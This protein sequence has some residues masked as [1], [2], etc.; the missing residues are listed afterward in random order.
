MPN[1]KKPIIKPILATFKNLQT[2]ETFFIPYTIEEVKKLPR[3]HYQIK[4]PSH[5]SALITIDYFAE[6]D[7]MNAAMQKLVKLMS[8]EN[9]V[10]KTA[11]IKTCLAV[12]GIKSLAIFH[13]T[14]LFL[15]PFRHL[16]LDD[17]LAFK[18]SVEERAPLHKQKLRFLFGLGAIIP[19]INM[20]KDQEE[21][22]AVYQFC[23]AIN[24]L[25]AEEIISAVWSLRPY[26]QDGSYELF[27]D[28][29]IKLQIPLT[30]CH[31]DFLQCGTFLHQEFAN[32]M[33][34]KEG[35]ALI[36][37]IESKRNTN[38][39]QQYAC[40]DYTIRD[41]VYGHTV[42]AI[43]ILMRNEAVVLKLLQLNAKGISVG[44]NLP[45]QKGQTPLLLAVA[46]GLPNVVAELIKQGAELSVV[47]QQGHALK[48]YL[49]LSP[50]ALREIV[51][52]IILEPNRVATA[53]R[54]YLH[55]KKNN[56]MWCW[57]EANEVQK[58]DDEQLTHLIVWS[59]LEKHLKRLIKV[60][61]YFKENH[62]AEEL[63]NV[64]VNIMRFFD[65]TVKEVE[66]AYVHGKLFE[67][68]KDKKTF[69]DVCIEGQILVRQLLEKNLRLACAFGEEEKVKLLLEIGINPNAADERKRTALHY[70]IAREG[71]VQQFA[72]AAGLHWQ[73]PQ[74]RAACHKHAAILELLLAVNVDIDA[75]HEG[76]LTAQ[77]VLQ[78]YKE[79]G[80]FDQ[81]IAEQCIIEFNQFLLS[82]DQSARL[83]S[84]FNTA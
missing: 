49:N 59:P 69:L 15:N 83:V 47:D 57:Y 7:V 8:D 6:Q 78:K 51:V 17:S 33:P 60:A 23:R 39:K 56:L 29:L 11:E 62:D 42:L 35:I 30:I 61:E 28:T 46:V 41:T 22:I 1:S 21:A 75:K 2:Q 80:G 9:Y 65:V 50:A 13:L 14:N 38:P 43:A 84:T 19:D 81:E 27:L 71:L 18:K 40:F 79:S 72:K 26:C 31:P 67:L 66:D 20:M 25:S 5:Q 82:H 16:M 77:E 53:Q 64:L 37:L 34:A 55:A 44:I 54:S 32:E 73:T 45:N 68:L 3:G 48:T 58:T 24:F 12:P 10:Q 63:E 36:E 76:G 74:V 52:P 70:A 4:T